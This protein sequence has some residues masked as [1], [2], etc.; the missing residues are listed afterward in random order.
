MEIVAGFC[1]QG[2]NFIFAFYIIENESFFS[3]FRKYYRGRQ[4]KFS[5]SLKYE[6]IPFTP[7][8]FK[9]KNYC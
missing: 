5:G 4:M 1:I 3:L 6:E 2:K 8:S 7:R 9:A